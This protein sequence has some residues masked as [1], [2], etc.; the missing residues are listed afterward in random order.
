MKNPVKLIA[1]FFILVMSAYQ[2][3]AQEK[4]LLNTQDVLIIKGKIVD[5]S[6]NL[7]LGTSTINFDKFGDELL[8]ADLDEQGNYLLVFDKN[9]LGFPMRMNFQIEGYEKF[10]AKKINLK[11]DFVKL[12]IA[13]IP[14]NTPDIPAYNEASVKWQSNSVVSTTILQFK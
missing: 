6:N 1:I 13:L 7:A 12:D 10:T 8:L 5:A 14:E 11:E 2:G 4:N 3:V 9:E